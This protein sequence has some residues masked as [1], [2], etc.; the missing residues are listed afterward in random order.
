ML[1]VDLSIAIYNRFYLT[2]ERA[3]IVWTL[4]SLA[5][6]DGLIDPEVND[7][8]YSAPL[9]KEHGDAIRRVLE[10]EIAIYVFR[11][12]N[13]CWGEVVDGM[14]DSRNEFINQ[15]REKTGYQIDTKQIDLIW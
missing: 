6:R 8:P 11:R 9:I 5:I 7:D 14:R 4:Y 12:L 2:A 3:G 15:Y 10:M 13:G 1:D